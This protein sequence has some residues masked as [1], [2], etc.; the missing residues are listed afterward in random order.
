MSSPPADRIPPKI[1]EPSKWTGRGPGLFAHFYLAL[2]IHLAVLVYAVHG[3]N[4]EHE[5]WMRGLWIVLAA[6][7]FLVANTR[8]VMLDLFVGMSPPGKIFYLMVITFFFI[9]PVALQ[10]HLVVPD[11]F[12]MLLF[13]LLLFAVTERMVRVLLAATLIGFWFACGPSPRPPLEVILGFGATTLWV[14]ATAHFSF[15]AEPFGLRGWWPIRRTIQTVLMV[16]GPAAL[17]AFVAYRFWPGFPSA[18]IGGVAATAG[19]AEPELRRLSEMERKEIVDALLRS[20]IWMIAI[21]ASLV[22]V[23]LVRRYFSQREKPGNLPK[24]RGAD[25]S[26]LDL[27]R[28]AKAA[29]RGELHGTRGQVVRLWWRWAREQEARG[30]ERSRGETASELADRVVSEEGRAAAPDEMTKI[31]ERAHYG[32]E[33]PTQADVEEMQRLVKAGIKDSS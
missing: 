9:S 11:G 8:I 18:E 12:V 27:V 23:Y 29:K 6:Q 10:G 5:A 30:I 28:S 25:V 26:Q 13:P 33:E 19:G 16:F 21:L 4:P 15:L 1:Q 17:A 32:D 20:L 31:L 24:L 7:T 14:L 2:F 22:A 3:R